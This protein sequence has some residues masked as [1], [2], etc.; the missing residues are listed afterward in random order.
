[1]NFEN[2]DIRSGDCENDADDGEDENS[3][4]GGKSGVP[5]WTHTGTKCGEE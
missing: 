2:D 3:N 4:T 1:M 5:K